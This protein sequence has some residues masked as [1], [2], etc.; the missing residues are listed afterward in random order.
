MRLAITQRGGC[1]MDRTV[2]EDEIVLVG[3]GR[4]ENE[5]SVSQRLELDRLARR[6]EGRQVAVPQLVGNR[7]TPNAMAVQRTVWPAGGS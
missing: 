3:H 4:A 1:R 7:Y 6:L 5:F 2:A